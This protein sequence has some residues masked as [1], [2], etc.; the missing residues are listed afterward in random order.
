[1][2]VAMLMAVPLS[3]ASWE[4]HVLSA[5]FPTFLM[6]ISQFSYWLFHVYYCCQDDDF[7]ESAYVPGK[8]KFVVRLDMYLVFMI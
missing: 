4:I 8:T 5:A 3:P 2:Q 1:M 7:D 6:F